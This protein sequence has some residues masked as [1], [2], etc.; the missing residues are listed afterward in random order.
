MYENKEFV[1]QVGKK[2]TIKC[3]VMWQIPYASKL[4]PLVS[5]NQLSFWFHRNE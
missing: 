1:H 5:G 4:R 2:M 3:D